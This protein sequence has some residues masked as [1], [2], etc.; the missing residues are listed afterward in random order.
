MEVD[1][2]HQACKRP[3]R[4]QVIPSERRAELPR[5]PLEV[6]RQETG[7]VRPLSR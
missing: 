6:V 1:Q 3:F 2:H 7:L 5:D 4:V